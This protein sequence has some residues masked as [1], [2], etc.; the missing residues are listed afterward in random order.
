MI[1]Q[2]QEAIL[3]PLTK[4]GNLPFRRLCI[5][6]G[7]RVTYSEMAYAKEMLRGAPRERALLKRHSSEKFFGVQIA[8]RNPQEA[9]EASKKAEDSGANFVD[10]NCGCPIH[11]AVKRGMGARLLQKP[12]EMAEIVAAM[13]AAVKIPVTVKVRIG[14][15]EGKINVHET[16]Q[17][18]EEAGAQSVTVHGR[19]REQRYTRAADWGL[20]AEVAARR[21]LEVVGNGDILTHYEADWHRESGVAALCIARGALIK[22]WIFQEIR[23]R[24]ELSLT[25]E[26]RLEIYWRLTQYMKEH[27]GEDDMGRRKTMTFLPWHFSFF[28]RYRSLPEKDWGEACRQHPL[29]QTRFDDREANLLPLEQLLRRHEESV[30]QAIAD[31]LWESADPAD[32]V[33]RASEL[34]LAPVNERSGRDA[35]ADE[36][37]RSGRR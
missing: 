33:T 27:F 32:A 7:A 12:E 1:F 31:L 20:I 17:A 23:E 36:S 34:K 14:Y 26:Q 6:F 11:E 10:L 24:H 28:H 8:A 37:G 2:H 29:L 30:H 4:G 21:K 18:V 15:Q 35:E 25:A 3:S 16:T 13:V 9:A 22:P 19:T 5:D